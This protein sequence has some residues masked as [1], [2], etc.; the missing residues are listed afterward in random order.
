MSETNNEPTKEEYLKALSDELFTQA[1]K[2]FKRLKVH[3]SYRDEVW[4]M[5]IVDMNELLFDNAERYI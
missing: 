1:R 4:S 5:D 2:K 3:A